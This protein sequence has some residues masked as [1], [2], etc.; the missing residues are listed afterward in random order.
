MP[1][2][3]GRVLDVGCGVGCL[4]EHVEPERY[5]GVDSDPAA[6]RAAAATYPSHRFVDS[7]PEAGPFDTVV[8]LAVVEHLFEPEASF[9]SWSRLLAPGGRIVVTTPHPSF[10]WLHE[11][12]AAIGLCS[13][14]AA[15]EHHRFFDRESIE[16]A[17]RAAGLRLEASRRFLGGVNQLF[18]LASAGAS[19]PHT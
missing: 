14:E 6:L 5:L 15:E 3:R 9:A 17:G 18:V 1:Y 2:V 13:R 16:R 19:K 4:A 8:A 10:I 12:G 11:A 7:L